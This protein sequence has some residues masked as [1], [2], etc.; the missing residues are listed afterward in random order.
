MNPMRAR[1]RLRIGSRRAPRGYV[2]DRTKDAS[3]RCQIRNSNEQQRIQSGAIRWPVPISDRCSYKNCAP[4]ARIDLGNIAC[5]KFAANTGRKFAERQTSQIEA[6]SFLELRWDD[7]KR[8]SAKA[9]KHVL[10]LKL[11]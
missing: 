10:W 9:A 11:A 8:S 4:K 6:S 7:S 5:R 3:K 1:I 2:S